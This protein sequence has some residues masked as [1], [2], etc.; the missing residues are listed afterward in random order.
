MTTTRVLSLIPSTDSSVETDRVLRL[1]ELLTNMGFEVRTLAVGPGNTTG[2]HEST[3]PA[4]AP[5][6]HSLAARTQTFRES[7]WADA[8]M[9]SDATL[10]SVLRYTM[11]RSKLPVVVV[12]DQDVALTQLKGPRWWNRSIIDQLRF[13]EPQ[14]ADQLTQQ[15]WY[16]RFTIS[17]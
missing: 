6:R 1:H 5:S 16:E 3:V 11:W 13:V 10:L 2:G 8:I 7:Q 17:N 15:D 12:T 4:I 14:T 9:M